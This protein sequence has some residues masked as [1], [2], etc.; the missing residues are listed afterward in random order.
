M[1]TKEEIAREMTARE[2]DA[3]Q[4]FYDYGH[5]DDDKYYRI[6]DDVY[7]EYLELLNLDNPSFLER[8]KKDLLN[9]IQDKGKVYGELDEEIHLDDYFLIVKGSFTYTDD[10]IG[11]DCSQFNVS[12]ITDSICELYVEMNPSLIDF[13]HE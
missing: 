4:Y 6:F 7:E 3:N 9:V 1:K 12:L 11:F 8:L 2:L 5:K 10:A 13:Y